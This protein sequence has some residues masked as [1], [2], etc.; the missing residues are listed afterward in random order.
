MENLREY[1][2]S[3]NPT[4]KGIYVKN[5]LWEL[6]DKFTNIDKNISS[7]SQFLFHLEHNINEIP[8]C[9]EN[10]MVYKQKHQRYSGC[11]VV[12]QKKIAAKKLSEIGLNRTEETRNNIKE[13]LS[14]IDFSAIRKADYE[15]KTLAKYPTILEDTKFLDNVESTLRQRVWHMEN[16]VFEIVKCPTCKT[17][18]AKYSEKHRVYRNCSIECV[19]KHHVNKGKNKS[20]KKKKHKMNDYLTEAKLGEFLKVLYPNHEFIHDRM[21]PNSNILNRPDYRN[22]ELKLIVEYDGDKHY[23]DTKSIKNDLLKDKTY[24]DV[25][26]YKVIRIP[27]FV[28]LSKESIKYYFDKEIE[29]EQIYPNGFISKNCILPADF[30]EWGTEI[31]ISIFNNLPKNIQVEIKDSIYDKIRILGDHRLVVNNRQIE[32]LNIEMAS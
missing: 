8:K 20:I 4:K 10:N 30:S 32:L 9:C 27:Y 6:K 7:S 23:K 5:N 16:K 21:V 24:I 17:K 26:G 18:N 3:L 2:L 22:D 31:F 11:S 25:L 12:C 29:I 13:S 14:K 28:Q 19:E 1:I 15:A